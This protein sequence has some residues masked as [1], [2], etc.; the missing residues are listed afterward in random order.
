MGNDSPVLPKGLVSTMSSFEKG[1]KYAF[2]TRTNGTTAISP[3]DG[4]D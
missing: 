4:V 2:H 1:R 3:G